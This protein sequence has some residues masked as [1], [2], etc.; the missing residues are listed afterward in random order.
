MTGAMLPEGADAVVPV[1]RADPA[2]FPDPGDRAATVTLPRTDAG[3][4]VRTAGSDVPAGT[5]AIRAG[6]RLN[7]AHLGLA[8]ALGLTGLA[9]RPRPRVLLVTTGDEVVLPGKRRCRP[10]RSTTPTRRCCTP[11]C[12]RP[13]RGAGGRTGAGR[14]RGTAAAL[15]GTDRDRRVDLIV[16]TGGI[17]AGAYEVVKQALAGQVEFCSVAMQPGGPQAP[18]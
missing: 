4:Y 14:P 18:G 5:I 11:P 8:A 7:A 1:E 9:V 10:A 16:T 6:V 3:A 15:D 12:A 13:G 17:S 2:A